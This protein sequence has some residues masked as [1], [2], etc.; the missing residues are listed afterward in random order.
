MIII[1]TPYDGDILYKNLKKT[2]KKYFEEKKNL[3]INNVFL[4]KKYVEKFRVW[5]KH[6]NKITNI[7][8][9]FYYKLKKTY[10]YNTNPVNEEDLT[11]EL[12][13]KNNKNV[14]I[15]DFEN[16]RKWWFSVGN[17]CKLINNCLCYFDEEMYSLC[18]KNI[19]N[20][21]TGKYLSYQNL[22]SIYY[23]LKTFGKIPNLLELLKQSNFDIKMFKLKFDHAINDYG[24]K[25]VIP[26]LS[27][28]IIMDLFINTC[29]LLNINYVS[30]SKLEHYYPIIK[31]RVIDILQWCYF[32]YNTRNEKNR[33]M[34]V[35]ITEHRFIMKRIRLP[36]ISNDSTSEN[37]N[38]DEIIENLNSDEED[39][40]NS[41][42]NDYSQE[43]P[44]LHNSPTRN[45]DED[46]DLD[47]NFEITTSI[48]YPITDSINLE[49]SNNANETNEHTIENM[50]LSE[51]DI[52]SNSDNESDCNNNSCESDCNDKNSE[53]DSDNESDCN[54]N[55]YD[56]DCNDTNCE[57]D[58]NDKNEVDSTDNSDYE[59]DCN[60]K[61]SETESSYKD[62]EGDS[63]S[64]SSFNSEWEE[65]SKEKDDIEW[66]TD[67]NNSKFEKMSLDDN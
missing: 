51:D 62:Y 37:I 15:Y 65:L 52:N 16:K 44:T 8:K 10:T 63:N 58:C 55:S 23:Q 14:Y 7:I 18:S 24:A 43:L 45:D 17:I 39:Y 46:F 54:D 36:T 5:I 38:N 66:E 56:S 12:Y 11:C 25:Y 29:S 57:S 6:N 22:L 41:N 60:D 64:E 61:I 26:T 42:N 30:H 50:E 9:K 4:D 49:I 59:S 35:F 28:T 27:D 13:N 33:S 32:S 67:S 19:I 3:I 2:E 48:V 47:S 53:V 20:P 40:E 34:R 21:Y 1:N 31:Y